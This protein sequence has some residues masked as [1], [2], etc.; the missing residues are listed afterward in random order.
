M[1]SHQYIGSSTSAL[2]EITEFGDITRPQNRQAR[3]LIDAVVKMHDGDVTHHYRHYP[4][5]DRK[6]SLLA[7]F[8]LEAAK[9]QHQFLPMYNA[10]LTLPSITCTALMA[11]ALQ[12]G[13][14]QQQFMDDLADDDLHR[15]IKL[16][17]EAGYRLGVYNT[18]TL[19]VDGYRFYG[20]FTMSRLVPFIHFHLINQS[21]LLTAQPGTDQMLVD[22]RITYSLE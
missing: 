13:F 4:S 17:F 7:A 21:K 11:Q 6:D 14:N 12:L 15:I 8:A 2:V 1:R 10:L 3:K 22:K 9:R 20:K 16:D 18:P 19:F 5:P